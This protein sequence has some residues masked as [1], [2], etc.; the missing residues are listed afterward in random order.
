MQHDYSIS[1]VAAELY[2]L[3]ALLSGGISPEKTSAEK[4]DTTITMRF[5]AGRKKQVEGRRDV[6]RSVLG[7]R[8]GTNEAEM[9]GKTSA[10]VHNQDLWRLC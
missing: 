6:C 8:P 9:M 5:Q 3:H 1:A 7:K 10:S 4:E 2:S